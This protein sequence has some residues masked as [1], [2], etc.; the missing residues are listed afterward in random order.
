MEVETKVKVKDLTQVKNKL[1]SMGAVFDKEKAQADHYYKPKGREKETQCPGSFIVR[2]R[3]MQQKSFLTVKLLTNVVGAWEEHETEIN[4]SEVMRK[5]LEKIGFSHVFSINKT[6]SAGKLGEFEVCIDDV[7]ELGKYLEIAL[8]SE[9]LKNKEEAKEK[10]DKLI[11]ELGFDKPD[12][13]HRGYAAIIS[14][15]MGI[16][17]EGGAG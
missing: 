7:K 14:Q 13:E 8:D 9:D 1:I 4:N 16:K 5:I 12:V 17:F 6:R 11:A 3:K 10:I 15:N 2:V